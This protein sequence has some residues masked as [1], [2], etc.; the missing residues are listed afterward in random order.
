VALWVQER[1]LDQEKLGKE[2]IKGNCKR[3]EKS[4]KKP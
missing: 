3:L 4:G 1:G 2:E